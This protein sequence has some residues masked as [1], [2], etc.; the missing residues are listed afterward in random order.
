MDL[1]G[2]GTE[3]AETCRSVPEHVHAGGIR[4]RAT[5]LDRAATLLTW[6]VRIAHRTDVWNVLSVGGAMAFIADVLA[7][8]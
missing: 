2:S 3:V 1:D 5:E 8:A 7:P 4:D 6:S